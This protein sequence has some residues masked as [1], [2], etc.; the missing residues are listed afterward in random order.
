MKYAPKGQSRHSDQEKLS[1][2]NPNK[3]HTRISPA[4]ESRSVLHR[5]ASP[6]SPAHA[7]QL[8][9]MIGNRAVSAMFTKRPAVP[10]AHEMTITPA[11]AN[12]P[13][14]RYYDENGKWV[15][16]ERPKDYVFLG[17]TK[18]GFPKYGPPKKEAEEAKKEEAEPVVNYPKAT[19]QQEEEIHKH[20][21][22]LLRNDDFMHDSKYRDG[23][24]KAFLNK[25][26]LRSAG[27]KAVSTADQ[28][29]ND[30]PNK[31]MS[32]AISTSNPDK[33]PNRT[34]Y[35]RNVVR[36]KLQKLLRAQKRGKPDAQ[37]IRV[38]STDDIINNLNKDRSLEKEDR[39]KYKNYA[40]KD[41]EYH[42]RVE[43]ENSTGKK[44]SVPARVLRSRFIEYKDYPNQ[45][46]SDSDTDI[47]EEPA[48]LYEEEQQEQ[49][50]QELNQEQEEQDL[51]EQEQ[52]Q[53]EQ[54]QEEVGNE[55]AVTTAE[56]QEEKKEQP[57]K[58]KRN[59]KKKKRNRKKT[60]GGKF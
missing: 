37:G 30:S 60:T 20:P 38:D 58:K 41:G 5:S 46:D 39:E 31:P 14:Q 32:N 59:N 33:A 47:E 29:N 28:M 35:G 52:E 25:T 51:E 24:R 8:Q 19:K 2:A 16:G 3:S 18:D 50:E 54:E 36:I 1:G 34:D 27:P 49:E 13:I 53:K 11:P 56:P 45:H 57:P 26:G 48:D 23:K 9:S 6:V 42:I 43:S 4:A 40:K 12:Q 21:K 17:L 10:A 44:D 15:D 55:T 22:Y 7:R